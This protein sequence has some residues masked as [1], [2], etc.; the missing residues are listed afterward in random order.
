MSDALQA[1]AR[2][3]G[4]ALTLPSQKNSSRT[5]TECSIGTCCASH[6]R[7]PSAPPTHTTPTF[8]PGCP[9][10][11]GLLSGLPYLLRL[12]LGAEK[13]SHVARKHVQP[14]HDVALVPQVKRER[15]RRPARACMRVWRQ[16]LGCGCV[17]ECVCAKAQYG[18]SRWPKRSLRRRKIKKPRSHGIVASGWKVKR[19]QYSSIRSE[20]PLKNTVAA[21]ATN[22][23]IAQPKGRIAERRGGPGAS[24]G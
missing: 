8:S 3:Q 2:N 18:C 19:S 12:E 5:D 6:C 9:G 13:G 20:R 14:G 1:R 10:A 4:A 15:C 24:D 11:E 23:L 16:R 17:L 22:G 7:T 21:T